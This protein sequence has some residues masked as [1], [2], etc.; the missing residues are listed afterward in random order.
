MSNVGYSE[1]INYGFSL[2]MYILGVGLLGAGLII[3]GTLI[4]AQ[5]AA[6]SGSEDEMAIWFFSGTGVSIFGWLVITAGTYG[7]FYKVIADAVSR[8]QEGTYLE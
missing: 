7:A 4:I 8:G 1:A 2:I 3:G 6:S 5:G